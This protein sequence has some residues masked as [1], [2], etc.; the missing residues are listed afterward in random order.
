MARRYAWQ[1][2]PQY[3]EA[4]TQARP[5]RMKVVD[6]TAEQP[7]PSA[8]SSWR[9]E[10]FDLTSNTVHTSGQVVEAEPFDE[11]AWFNPDRDTPEPPTYTPDP[12]ET[13]AE[14][15]AAVEKY[16]DRRT[17]DYVLNNREG[18]APTLFDV[19]LR[20]AHAAPCV[21]DYAGGPAEW[22]TDDVYEAGL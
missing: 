4:P 7:Q 14:R 18:R 5:Y 19:E 3:R 12:A 1:D 8:Q 20:E 21:D 11:S 2:S 17:I 9:D 16:A 6:R 15:A 13:K 22:D 10:P